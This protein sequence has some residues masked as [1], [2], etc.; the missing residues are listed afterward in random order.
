MHVAHDVCAVLCV[1]VC[2]ST[3]PH[4]C[5]CSALRVY[6]GLSVCTYV[7]MNLLIPSV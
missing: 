3:V 5:L 1:L 6:I 7:Y 2:I 4:V